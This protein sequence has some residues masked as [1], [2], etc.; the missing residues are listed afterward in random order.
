MLEQ[1]GL[2]GWRL[3]GGGGAEEGRKFPYLQKCLEGMAEA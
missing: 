3:G 2:C 1:T